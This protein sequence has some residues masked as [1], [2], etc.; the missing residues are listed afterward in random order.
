MTR[1]RFYL[2]IAPAL[3]FICGAAAVIMIT[4]DV[5]AISL[6]PGY[7]PLRESIS[8]LVLLPNGWLEEWGM[9]AAGIANAFLAGLMISSDAGRRYRGLLVSG[10]LFAA[11]TVCFGVIIIFNT[12]PGTAVTTVAG[13]IHVAAVILLAVLF[14]VTGLVLARSVRGFP[15]AA[16]VGNLARIM[17]VIGAVV[18]WQVLPIH[19]DTFIGLSE[20]FLSGV[21][22]AWMV[23]AGG[24]LPGLLE[25]LDRASRGA[26]D[27]ISASYKR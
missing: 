19:E 23:F 7:D 5:I 4:S 13:G 26:A 25:G 1:R 3:P 27:Q 18:A 21:G 24:H 15:D 9:A 17:A 2:V 11:S 12:D 22:L 14:P 8:D 16:A 20:R 10:G 6:N